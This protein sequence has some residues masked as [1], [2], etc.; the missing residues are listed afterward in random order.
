M[1]NPGLVT[2]GCG[3]IEITVP[4]GAEGEVRGFFGEKIRTELREVFA[5]VGILLTWG[6]LIEDEG[7]DVLGLPVYESRPDGD[8]GWLWELVIQ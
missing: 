1:Q 2:V 8:S 7:G 5:E 6:P 4:Q 3:D